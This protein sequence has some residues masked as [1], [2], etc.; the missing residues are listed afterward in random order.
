M[1]T[2][3]R[4]D[5]FQ[6]MQAMREAMDKMFQERTAVNG[7]RRVMPALDLS[8]TD[9]AYVVEMVV[10][11]LKAEDLDI[12]FE[13]GV[14]TVKGEI[15]QEQH[16]EKRYFHRIERRFGSFVR[17]ISLPRSIQAEQISASLSNGIL[18]LDIPKAE[19]AKPRKINVSVNTLPAEA[20]NN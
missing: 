7:S 20:N 18:R 5:P 16:E 13:N 2:I 8:E 12:S 10:P 3:T 14:L 17:T 1:S 15:K 4:W 9:V 6:E 19:V 11:G